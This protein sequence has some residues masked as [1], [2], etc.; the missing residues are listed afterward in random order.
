MNER[1]EFYLA[2]NVNL[3]VA[4]GLRRRGIDVLATQEAGMFGASDEDHLALATGQNRILFTQD[5]DFLRLH[6][7]GIKH[8]GIVYVHQRTS[9]GHISR[10][11][12]LI[13]QVLEPDEMNN[14]LEFL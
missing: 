8:T 10:A 2:E 13:Y 6:A 9:I 7:Q 3:A 14:R 12:T 5:D 1:V 4:T 11:L